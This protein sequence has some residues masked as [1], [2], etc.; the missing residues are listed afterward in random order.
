MEPKEHILDERDELWVRL[1]RHH[2]CCA[3]AWQ[4]GALSCMEHIGVVLAAADDSV[5][6]MGQHGVKL[7][8]LPWNLDQ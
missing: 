6:R 2:L 7:T 3:C 4:R 5:L 1:I 8:L